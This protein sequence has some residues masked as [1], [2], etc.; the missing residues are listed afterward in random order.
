M[1][2][3]SGNWPLVAGQPVQVGCV[4]YCSGE[5]GGDG[6]WRNGHRGVELAVRERISPAEVRSPDLINDRL[7]KVTLESCGQARAVPF[8]IGYAPTDTQ[9]VGGEKHA[10]WTALER[11][12]KEE[13]EHEQLTV[14]MDANNANLHTGWRGRGRAWA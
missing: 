11:F 9:A 1:S 4:V 13:P 12:G 10:F 7:L 8:V 6:G 3:F 5:S 2:L 14:F